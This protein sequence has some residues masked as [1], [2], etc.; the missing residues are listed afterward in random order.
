MCGE[1]FPFYH[2]KDLVSYIGQYIRLQMEGVPRIKPEVT[3]DK[4]LDSPSNL[5]CV[6]L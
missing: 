2:S 5:H 1:S 4:L 6:Y 3:S